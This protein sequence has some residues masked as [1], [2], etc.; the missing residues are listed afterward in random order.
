MSV[1]T[2]MITLYTTIWKVV[3]RRRDRRVMERLIETRGP[4]PAGSVAIVVYFADSEVNLYQARQWYEPMAE[5][6]RHHGVAFLA[7]NVAGSRALLE[8][9]P[10]PVVHRRTISEIEAWM[11]TQPVTTIYYVNQNMRNFQM[12]RFVRRSCAAC[13]AMNV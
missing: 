12:M 13:P 11:A 8:E 1:F 10:I 5:L 2:D 3:T 7:R 4:V 6:A 9:S